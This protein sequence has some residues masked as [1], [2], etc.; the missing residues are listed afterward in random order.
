MQI[1]K[2]RNELTLIHNHFISGLYKHQQCWYDI[3]HHQFRNIIKARQVGATFYFAR[4]ALIDA[5][6]NNRD[7]VFFT[8]E[9]NIFSIREQILKFSAEICI[10]FHAH[11]ST[12]YYL[13]FN[14][15]VKIYIL[16]NLEQL[17]KLSDTPLDPI[18]PTN[19][20]FDEYFYIPNFE[21]IYEYASKVALKKLT[22]LTLYSSLYDGDIS[23]DDYPKYA[24]YLWENHGKTKFVK[25]GFVGSDGQFRQIVNIN[26]LREYPQFTEK[27]TLRGELGLDL[28]NKL[29]MC[30]FTY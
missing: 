16:H 17:A 15:N 11:L 20:Y 6:S 21:H 3:N 26:N 10:S 29:Y 25:D 8:T 9:S 23:D 2:T 14:N 4:E 12:E 28:F 22:R 18:K 24:N 13:T 27:D 1:L 30:N 5:I 7:Q 19:F